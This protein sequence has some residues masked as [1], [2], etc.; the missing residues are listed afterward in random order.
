MRVGYL[1]VAEDEHTLGDSTADELTFDPISA[2]Q[3]HQVERLLGN[4]MDAL[5]RREQEI[6]QG[7][8]GL[9]D[10]EP[11]TLDALS[12]RLELTRERVRQIQNEALQKLKRFMFRDGITMQVLL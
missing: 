3:N 6:L 2:I 1:F 12:E 4:W 8:F 11:E 9:Y 7:R 5:S 10:R